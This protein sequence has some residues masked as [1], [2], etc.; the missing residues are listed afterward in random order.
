MFLLTLGFSGHVRST[1]SRWLPFHALRLSD[2]SDLC[3]CYEDAVQSVVQLSLLTENLKPQ[4]IA[5]EYIV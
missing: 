1:C 3:F 4:W 5:A 2:S